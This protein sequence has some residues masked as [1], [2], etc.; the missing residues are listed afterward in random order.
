MLQIF[1]ENPRAGTV[2]CR[3]HFEDNTIQHD[4]I[5]IA[6]SKLNN[7]FNLGHINFKNYYN[8][9]NETKEVIGN[10]AGLMLVR[11]NVFE[12]VGLFSENY[13]SCFEDVELNVKITS[14]GLKNFICGKCV[15]Y[16]YE[17]QTR[18]EDSEDMEKQ[19]TD[20]MKLIPV[21]NDNWEKIKEKVFLI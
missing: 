1:K 3:L 6:K 18:K 16:H 13:L 5:F 11:K 8:F 10:T 4:G 19:K 2:G 7:S 14:S 9:F 20:Y 17:S 12:N 15:A 21:I